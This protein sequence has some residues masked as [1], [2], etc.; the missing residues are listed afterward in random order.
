MVTPASSELSIPRLIS[1]I[2]LNGLRLK[3]LSIN[4]DAAFTTA[5]DKALLLDRPDP[6]GRLDSVLIS[7]PSPV[8]KS[9]FVIESS[10]EL[11]AAIS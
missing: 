5:L 1:S 10:N 4:E 3:L 8:P 9:R 7:M 6:R 2:S 11:S